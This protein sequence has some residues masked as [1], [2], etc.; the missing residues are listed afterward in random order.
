[1]DDEEKKPAKKKKAAPKK[2]TEAT[3]KP[4][5][6]E[7]AE[8]S[9]KAEKKKVAPKKSAPKAAAKKKTPAAETKPRK[10][11]KAKAEKEEDEDTGPD[12]GEGKPGGKSLVIVESPAKAKTINKYLGKDYVVKASFGHVRDLP[13]KGGGL[14]VDIEAKFEPVYKLLSEK[15]KVVTELKKAAR[16]SDKIFLACD[17]DREGEAIAWHISEILKARPERVSRIT[18]NEIT[19]S[20]IER[21]IQQPRD[22]DMAK[23]NAQQARRILDRI[24]GYKLSPILWKKVK[25]GLSAGRV[26]SVAVKLVVERE[27]EIK[28][29]N[30]IE[31]WDLE[32]LLAKLDA[33]P[34]PP[35]PPPSEVE[36]DENGEPIAKG[37]KGEK[38]EPPVRHLG[39]GRFFAK[40][41]QVG[42]EKLDP[43][44]FR[45]KSAEEAAAL[46]RELETSPFIVSSVKKAERRDNPSAPFITSTLQQQASTRLR[47]ATNKTMRVAQSLY[48]GVELGEEGAVGLITY[49][50]T[51]STN[52]AKEAI[53]EARNF[54]EEKYGKSYLPD[55]PPVYKSKAGAQEAHEAIRPTQ[56][57]RTPESV[58]KFLTP[59]QYKLYKLI[60]ERFI[61]C[62]MPAAV[63]SQTTV[64]V[65]AGKCLFRANGRT[66]IF[67]G[68]LKVSGGGKKDE[69][70]LPDL[71]E[72]EKLVAE[73]LQ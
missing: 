67:D 14:G 12:A 55:A 1:M 15:K 28:A 53:E 54:I 13:E 10:G 25:R 52:L 38:K 51:D 23:V 36:L 21:A 27:R 20:A 18:F 42:D 44:K 59:D 72:Q 45:V 8:K 40:L 63:F 49:M 32:A 47:F 41:V 65:T 39:P 29:F 43:E 7:K 26:Q 33:P 16:E 66:L 69:P 60:W 35:P 48:E 57:T 34:A 24:V 64:E 73:K 22:L 50:R 46:K 11:K 17:N 4:E 68:H 3:T 19:K 62:Q 61:A 9:E 70:I 71:A 31:Y 5:K 56:A 2:K 30:P 6:A 58:E 37:E